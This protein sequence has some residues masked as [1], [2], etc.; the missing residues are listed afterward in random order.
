MNKFHRRACEFKM[1]IPIS[2]GITNTIEFT[3]YSIFKATIVITILNKENATI[4]ITI[5]QKFTLK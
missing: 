1:H 4:V 5:L 2:K 3:E